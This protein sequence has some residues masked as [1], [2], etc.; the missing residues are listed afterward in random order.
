MCKLH[1]RGHRHVYVE[2]IENTVAATKNS[3]VA[4]KKIYSQK[5]AV[6][7]GA[8]GDGKGVKAKGLNPP[9]LDYTDNKMMSFYTDGDLFREIDKGRGQ[10][11][12]F[13]KMLTEKDRWNLVNYIRTLSTMG[14]NDKVNAEHN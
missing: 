14:E 9:P 12:S 5:C 2:E 1:K 13:A 7:H 10:M 6:C 3:V 4:G 8:K 11:P